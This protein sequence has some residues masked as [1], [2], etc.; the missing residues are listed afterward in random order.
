MLR[1]KVAGEVTFISEL[2]ISVRCHIGTRRIETCDIDTE[3][4]DEGY[5]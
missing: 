1:S 3:G 2:H 5:R 4:K